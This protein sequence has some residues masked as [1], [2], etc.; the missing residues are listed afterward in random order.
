MPEVPHMLPNK[1]EMEILHSLLAK[2]Y[3][4]TLNEAMADQKMPIY[5]Q[6]V[7]KG[8]VS[9]DFF[10]VTHGVQFSITDKGRSTYL[11]KAEG[12]DY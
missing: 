7:E 2:P 1:D 4:S 3:K 10:C 6:L 5:H 11:K 9:Q 12:F 8:W